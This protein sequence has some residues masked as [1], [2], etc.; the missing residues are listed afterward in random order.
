MLKS[1]YDLMF[2]AQYAHRA[3]RAINIKSYA[4]F[5]LPSPTENKFRVFDQKVPIFCGFF[6][7]LL[8]LKLKE[9]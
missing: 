4:D 8:K 3:Y 1:A 7:V 2:T 6:F 9:N 5:D